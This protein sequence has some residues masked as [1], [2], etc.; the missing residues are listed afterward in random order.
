MVLEYIINIIVQTESKRQTSVF[1]NENPNAGTHV[2]KVTMG[3]MPD[4]AFDGTGMRID[5]VTEGKA[6]F[7]SRIAPRRHYYWSWRFSSEQ[8][9]GLYEGTLVTLK[10]RYDQD[11]NYSRRKRN[12]LT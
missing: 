12:A 9:D 1:A 11:Q 10:R 5:G 6:W 8:H 2:Y 3:V 4:Y 7:Q